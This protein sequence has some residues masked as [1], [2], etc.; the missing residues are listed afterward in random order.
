MT[1]T[2]EATATQTP[3]PATAEEKALN[4]RETAIKVMKANPPTEP[5]NTVDAV[6][7][8]IA[9]ETGLPFKRARSYYR[10]IVKQVDKEGNQMAPGH[11]FER[12]AKPA[13]AVKE[14]AEEQKAPAKASG[15][16][17]SKAA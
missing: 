9:D 1:N 4:K 2:T 10:W 6:S 15:K 12:A 14:A 7:Q 8:K 3:A 13:E 17:P 5:E 16:K 11:K